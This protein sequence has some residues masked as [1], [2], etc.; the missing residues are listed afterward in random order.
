MLCAGDALDFVLDSLPL[1]PAA[2]TTGAL[3]PVT[4][5]FLATADAMLVATLSALAMYHAERPLTG[6]R[7]VAVSRPDPLTGGDLFGA[8]PPVTELIP[9]PPPPL[10]AQAVHRTPL[11]T[12]HPHPA[13]I[14]AS[15]P[16][17]GPIVD[18]SPGGR[19]SLSGTDGFGDGDFHF[20]EDDDDEDD[21]GGGRHSTLH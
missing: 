5:D 12:A 18:E 1:A 17:G 15:V 13:A 2:P 3:P 20:T 4:V 8:S 9:M 11:P 10:P 6:L 7:G 16:I 14:P 19:T 21:I